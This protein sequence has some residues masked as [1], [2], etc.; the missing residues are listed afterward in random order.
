MPKVSIIMATY[1]CAGT[2]ARAIDSILSQ[3]LTDWEFIICD[4]G[5]SDTTV[6]ILNEYQR[7]YPGKIILLTNA[8]NSKLPF[9]LNRCLAHAHGEFIARMDADDISLPRRL[10]KQVKYLEE[11]PEHSVVGTSMLRFDERGEY[12]MVKAVQHPD[13]DTLLT[14][15]PFCHA[16]ILMR[17]SA[18]DALGGYVVS[19]RTERGQDLDLWFRFFAKGFS[20]NNL[21]EALYK[22]CED[23]ATLRRRKFKYDLYLT[24]T[25]F[26]GFRMLRF[27]WWKYPFVLKSFVSFFTPRWIKLLWRK[28]M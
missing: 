5:S 25:R 23:R 7:S 21:P 9:S 24:Q 22:A 2:V 12:G 4:D 3:T 20:G 16:T 28:S 27:P 15:V 8:A 26:L 13:K 19:K 14:Q 1:N 6:S 17:K 11:H 18:Y 10:E